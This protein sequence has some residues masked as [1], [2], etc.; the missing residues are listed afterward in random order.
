MH[1]STT[2]ARARAR[3][4]TSRETTNKQTH[5]RT[6]DT[7]RTQSRTQLYRTILTGEENFFGDLRASPRA[8]RPGITDESLLARGRAQTEHGNLTQIRRETYVRAADI[9]I[10][11]Y[12]YIYTFSLSRDRNDPPARG[13]IA[14][15]LSPA[16]ARLFIS[17][18]TRTRE[19]RA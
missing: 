18:D 15:I 2:C 6:R 8:K 1:G 13:M 4:G 11:I 9:Y 14:A 3:T 16:P 10:Y 12:I 5:T 19:A 7:P 17:A